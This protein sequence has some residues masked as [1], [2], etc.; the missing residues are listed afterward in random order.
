MATKFDTA[1]IASAVHDG[2]LAYAAK[3]TGI[4]APKLFSTSGMFQG[5][6]TKEVRDRTIAAVAATPK[7][8]RSKV[9][10]HVEWLALA[11]DVKP[12]YFLGLLDGTRKPATH[13]SAMSTSD[14]ATPTNKGATEP[15]IIPNA[16]GRQ[17]KKVGSP[18]EAVA[19][20]YAA[21]STATLTPARLPAGF[22]QVLKDRGLLAAFQ[23]TGHAATA[24]VYAAAAKQF[25]G[26]NPG[27][28]GT[29]WKT[30]GIAAQITQ[31]ASK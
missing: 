4:P 8:Q 14:T 15:T 27:Y 30:T 17:T 24:A 28:K 23:E 2:H 16:V 22:F 6:M 18:A 31:A 5:S 21:S 11:W 12:A 10:P 19:A 13:K 25:M 29:V 20:V 3:L 26:E 9:R 1:G 7:N